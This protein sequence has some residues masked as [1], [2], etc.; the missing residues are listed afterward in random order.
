MSGIPAAM[1]TLIIKAIGVSI[2]YQV[3]VYLFTDEEKPV[4]PKL[5]PTQRGDKP[6]QKLR[7][8]TWSE[9]NKHE[10]IGNC[11]TCG[12]GLF[13]KDP[14]PGLTKYEFARVKPGK[15]EGKYV[16]GN[17][18]ICCLSCNRSM[19]SKNLYLFLSE[20]PHLR[21][22]GRKNIEKYFSEHPEERMIRS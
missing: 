2:A 12:V 13:F 1:T 8:E 4:K 20:N 22:Q 17:V 18:R 5:S 9:Y 10:N 11:Y 15:T 21:G 3:I 16:K 19:S 14:V 7:R 6:T